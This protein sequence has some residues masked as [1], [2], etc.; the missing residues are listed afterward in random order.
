MRGGAVPA[1]A[2]QEPLHP[3]IEGCD[4]GLTEHA[5][6]S[7]PRWELEG[8]LQNGSV[9]SSVFGG[10]G[11]LV[12]VS[13]RSGAWKRHSQSRTCIK[14]QDMQQGPHPRS[15]R[16]DSCPS[17]VGMQRVARYGFVN[18]LLFWISSLNSDGSS[19]QTLCLLCGCGSG[20]RRPACRAE[21]QRTRPDHQ[22]I[23]NP[24][25]PSLLGLRR[26]ACCSSVQACTQTL[27]STL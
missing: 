1:R 17:Y 6:G 3:G 15:R 14:R 27:T 10:R 25:N 11:K 5:A 22:T 13:K 24:T 18:V 7:E 21:G 8:C 19:C 26:V 16:W 20:K 23:R 12:S 9:L 2:C 4:R